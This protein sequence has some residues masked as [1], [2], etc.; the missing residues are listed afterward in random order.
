MSSLDSALLVAQTVYRVANFTCMTEMEAARR[1][2]VTFT[3]LFAHQAL[4]TVFETFE[5]NRRRDLVDR[6]AC[7]CA[8]ERC[9]HCLLQHPDN[10]LKVVVG[11]KT[12][13]FRDIKIGA[14]WTEG[15]LGWNFLDSPVGAA[16]FRRGA[17][18]LAKHKEKGSVPGPFALTFQSVLQILAA[19]TGKMPLKFSFRGGMQ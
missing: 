1:T 8:D 2:R 15:P 4:R 18:L 19:T 7:N 5:S 12:F 17:L 11:P 10:L 3:G 14:Y 16:R 6:Q 9:E 13:D